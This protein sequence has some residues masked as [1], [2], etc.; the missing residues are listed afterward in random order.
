MK[1]Y[2]SVIIPTYNQENGLY[3][4]LKR[5]E[6]TLKKSLIDYNYEIIFINDGS[7]DST[8]Y[9]LTKLA[10]INKNVKVIN[11]SRNFG[12]QIAIK[13]G[14][15]NAI[16][17]IFVIMDDDLQD[18]PELI[19]KLLKKYKDGFDI[20]HARRRERKG[21][22]VLFNFLAKIFYMLINYLSDTELPRNVGD[23]RLFSKKVAKEVID[24]EEYDLYFRGLFKWVGFKDAYVD[25]VRHQRFSGKTNFNLIKYVSFALNSIASFSNKPLNLIFVFGF[26]MFFLSICIVL[27]FII[28]KLLD[29]SYNIRGWTSLM[30]AIIF[31]GSMNIMFLGV[32]SFYTGKIF[33]Q[34][35]KRSLYVIDE[36]INF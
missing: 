8:R 28:I 29:P 32:I 1:S 16:G 27:Y 12:N 20:V 19:P 10:K 15:E 6:A 34:S 5:I 4:L 35:K 2:L 14:I 11:F 3:D 13:A 30:V 17:D 31:F 22:S 23:F 7:Y 21:T 26:F 36:K 24:T 18:P 33:N 9:V 25:F